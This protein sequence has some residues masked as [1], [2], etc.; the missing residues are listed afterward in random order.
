MCGFKKKG[1]SRISSI[2]LGIGKLLLVKES[3]AFRSWRKKPSLLWF[4]RFLC[5]IEQRI[6]F[7]LNKAMPWLEF[8]IRFNWYSI[9]SF[10]RALVG[11]SNLWI[12][13]IF[14]EFNWVS[15]SK[16]PNPPF[17]M[18][19]WA[20]CLGGEFSF[21]P[22]GNHIFFFRFLN[23]FWDCINLSNIPKFWK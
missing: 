18:G 11:L 3:Q 5:L 7:C 6:R 8:K 16:I 23:M 12:H 13:F 22:I 9:R 20:R 17:Q 2:D 15:M 10:H 1:W 14:R 19:S 4:C 21:P